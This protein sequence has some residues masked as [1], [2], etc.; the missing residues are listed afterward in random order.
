VV[1]LR[2]YIKGGTIKKKFNHSVEV[3]GS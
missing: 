1:G 2:P 3:K